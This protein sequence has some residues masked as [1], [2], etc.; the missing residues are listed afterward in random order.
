MLHCANALRRIA[1]R[2][3]I[4]WQ[5]LLDSLKIDARP[6]DITVSS[7]QCFGGGTAIRG[8]VGSQNAPFAS[9]NDAANRKLGDICC[10]V[11]GSIGR[12]LGGLTCLTPNGAYHCANAGA[13]I[14]NP[15][16]HP[17]PERIEKAGWF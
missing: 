13:D 15:L 3:P 12:S 14:G 6:A 9:T 10:G 4:G 16:L 11:A 7:A 5:A 17:V 8:A 1:T 2:R